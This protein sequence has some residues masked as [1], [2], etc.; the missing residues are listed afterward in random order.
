MEKLRRLKTS[1]PRSPHTSAQAWGEAYGAAVFNRR[2]FICIFL[3]LA[4]GGDEM[5]LGLALVE[6]VVNDYMTVGHFSYHVHFVGYKNDC[7]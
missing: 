3:L 6:S 1:S 2:F 7:G 4:G 5:A